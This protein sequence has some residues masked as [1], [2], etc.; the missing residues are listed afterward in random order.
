MKG[1]V[2]IEK[3]T[4]VKKFE[5]IQIICED[6]HVDSELVR[7]KTDDDLTVF[8][9]KFKATCTNELPTI[10]LHW[11]FPASNVKGVWHPSALH[12]KRLKADWEANQ[13]NSRISV[14][15]PVVCLFGHDDSNRLTFAVADSIHPI[16]ME[17]LLREEDCLIYCN[18]KFFTEKHPALYHYETELRIDTRAIQFG[19]ALN[20]VSAWWDSFSNMKSLPVPDAAKMPVYSTWYAYHQDLSVGKLLKECRL[21]A[22]VGFGS[23]IID[24][25][26][27]TLDNNRGYDF[28][29]DW[30][31]ERIPDMS[32]FVRQVHELDMKFLI[33]YSVPFCGKKSRVYQRFEGKFLTESNRWASVLDPRYPE[34]R[35]YLVNT[36]TNAV[37]KWHLDGLKLDFIDEFKTY[38]GVE[39]TKANG[40]DYASVNE[41]VEKLLSDISSSLQAIKSNIMI[42][43]RQHYIGPSIKKF[44]NMFRAFDSP[45]DSHTNRV[46]TTD[47]RLLNRKAAVH[48]DMLTWHYHEPVEVAALQYLNVIMSVPQISVRLAEIPASHL[49][50]VRFYTDYWIEN[51]EL[52]IDGEFTALRPLA[53]YPVLSIV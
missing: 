17:A 53:N 37:K 50:M 18:V 12:D 20:S 45:N 24:D 23:I 7:I 29:G 44:G 47:I 9:L 15:A 34:V 11:K 31:P 14:D 5:D 16:K 30:I 3:K 28:T 21:A 38:E 26:W 46:R 33:W 27:Q 51:R 22:K 49:E 52:L 41:A 36:Y 13:V 35:E 25:G 4:L 43:F 19:E 42:E 40:R 2:H 1:E 10:H 8:K 6:E 39:F 32:D 48:S